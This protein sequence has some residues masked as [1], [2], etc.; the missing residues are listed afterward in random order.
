MSCLLL[1]SITSHGQEN[2]TNKVALPERYLRLMHQDL[3]LFDRV[4]YQSRF[5]SIRIHNLEYL[6]RNT[7]LLMNSKDRECDMRVE[8]A[9][10]NYLKEKKRRG[11]TEF[12]LGVTLILLI[13]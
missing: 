5:D 13:L 2:D 4:R 6:N 12:L 10:Q 11:I 1:V 3:E 7:I 8:E 9:E